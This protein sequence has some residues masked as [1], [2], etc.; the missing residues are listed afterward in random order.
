VINK[1]AYRLAG[2]SCSNVGDWIRALPAVPLASQRA[3]WTRV[4]ALGSALN[5]IGN[6]TYVYDPTG[7]TG[8]ARSQLIRDLSGIKG[9]AGP[10]LNGDPASGWRGTVLI[11]FYNDEHRGSELV[12]WE[13]GF[14][15]WGRMTLLRQYP[16]VAPQS[17]SARVIVEGP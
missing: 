10:A 4:L 15:P 2:W 1:S 3:V 8:L 5:P 7:L 11:A 17:D 6:F 16:V 9:A 14:D 13:F 12:K